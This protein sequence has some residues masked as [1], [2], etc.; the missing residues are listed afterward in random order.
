MKDCTITGVETKDIRFPTSEDLEGSDAMNLDPDYSAA[1]VILKTDHPNGMDGHGLTFTI[2]RGNELC[3]QAIESL[4]YLLIG[5]TL[6]SFTQNMGDFWKMITGDSQLRWLGPDKGVIHLATGALVNAV[7]DLYAK[8]EQK[9]LWQLIADMNPEELIDCIDFSYITDAISKDEALQLLKEKE[10]G[11]EARRIHLKQN[12]YPAYTTS[13]GWLGYSDE[14][15]RRLCREAKAE[16]FNHIK[17][18]VG[19]DL[20][21]DLRRS[22]IIREEIGYDIKLMMDANQKW[23]VDEA[24]ENI[25]HLAQFKPWWIE[26]PTSPDDILGHAKIAQAIQPIHVATGEHCQN[27]VVFKQ[28]MQANAIGICQID[29][30]RVGG[31]NEILAILLM[32]AKFNIPV[33]PHAGGV[34]LCEQ[35]QHLSMIDY[36]CI[37]GSMENRIIEYVD[38]LH[39]HF[40]DPVVIQNGN[41]LPPYL[42]GYS[43]EMKK[44]ALKSYDFDTGVVWKKL[45]AINMNIKILIFLISLTMS[46]SLTPSN[47]LDQALKNLP[48]FESLMIF[49][50]ERF[51]NVVVATDG[52]VMAGWGQ[53]NCISRRREDGGAPWELIVYIDQGIND[54]GLTLDENS[55]N[56]ITFIKKGKHPPAPIIICT[57]NDFG[58]SWQASDIKIHPDKKGNLPSIHMNDHGVTLKRGK[59]KGRLIRPTKYYSQSNDQV[60]WSEHYTNIIYSHNRRETWHTSDPFPVNGTR[61]AAVVKLENGKIYYNSRRHMS[62]DSLNPR[63]HHIAASNN[64][65]QSWERLYVSSELS[66][67]GQDRDYILMAGLDRLPFDSHDIFIFSNIESQSWRKK[68][69]LRLSFDTGKSWPIKKI[70]YPEGFKYSSI[71]V[72]RR[73][74]PSEGYIYV[75]YETGTKDNINAYGGGKIAPFNFS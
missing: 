31:V 57:S 65:G 46:C 13:A 17:M 41:Y 73:N 67:G 12:G 52:S 25:K 40:V 42:P 15:I 28:L 30:C 21:D 64:G 5:K 1:Y 43:I 6:S 70:I 19:S 22:K 71:A 2:G 7:W 33:C 36:L 3:V 58:Q 44:E 48:F 69:M 35:V 39:E 37:S 38:H 9:P 53:K 10:K 63:M 47:Q 32:A 8:M 26:E 23:E 50:D 62:T 61:E 51:Y 14:K 56:I 55:G 54:D 20:Q 34:G 29:S 66:D 75:L 59:Y 27:R 72:E 68:G 49:K 16:G 60:Y 18:K 74:T 24:I 4:S 11:K 45:K